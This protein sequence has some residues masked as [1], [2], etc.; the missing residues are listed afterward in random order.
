MRA[1]GNAHCCCGWFFAPLV[2]RKH[3]AAVAG[4]GAPGAAAS[5]EFDQ[6]WSA[7]AKNE[8]DVF[9]IEDDRGE[10]LM[11]NVRRARNQPN[12]RPGGA[13]R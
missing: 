3:R 10:G 7:L 13:R 12:S 8:V 1:C 5:P 2:V 6:K 4:S 9:Y 11:G